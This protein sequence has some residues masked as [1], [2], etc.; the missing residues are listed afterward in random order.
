GPPW[1]EGAQRRA[2]GPPRPTCRAR[3]PPGTA[4]LLTRFRP[5]CYLSQ[6]HFE[7]MRPLASARKEAHWSNRRR[8]T[9]PLVRRTE[10]R[11]N[12]DGSRAPGKEPAHANPQSSDR[13]RAARAPEPG[14]GSADADDRTPP[15]PGLTWPALRHDGPWFVG[16]HPG[17]RA[18]H[19]RQ[20]ADGDRAAAGDVVGVRRAHPPALHAA[21]GGDVPRRDA[22]QRRGRQVHL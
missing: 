14:H 8:S 20:P 3:P 6:S 17:P 11:P 9:E 4:R 2:A 1:T 5:R 22:V 19:H 15:P 7:R 12:T 21:R 16:L 10:S 18:A 13:R